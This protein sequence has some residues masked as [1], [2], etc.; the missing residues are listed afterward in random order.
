MGQ[1]LSIFPN[2]KLPFLGPEL[3]RRGTSAHKEVTKTMLYG[4]MNFPI[5]PVMEEIEEIAQL[6]FDFVELAMDPPEGHHST[7][8][9]QKGALLGALE[10]FG[11][12][13]ICHLPT[14]VSTADLTGSLREASLKEVL[15]SLDVAADLGPYKV[16]LHPSHIRGL[17][18]HVMDMARGYALRS[19]EAIA[20]RIEEL[21]LVACMEN[22]FPRAHSL[23]SPKEFVRVFKRFPTLKFTLDT[24]HAHIDDKGGKRVLDFIARFP[25]RINHVHASDNFGKEDN[26]LPIGTGTI[27]FPKIIKALKGIGYNDT[28]TFEVFSRDRDYLRISREKFAGMYREL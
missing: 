9:Q 8:R 6:G 5:R 28:V 12:D 26:H 11:M 16:V 19:L 14:F 1:I 27:D 3:M 20:Q 15:D 4:A 23:V 13:L 25:D 7:I 21:G 22:M 2:F 10:G 18:P 24:G 17:G